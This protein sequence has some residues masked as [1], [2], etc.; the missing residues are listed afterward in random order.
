MLGLDYGLMGCA[1]RQRTSV[2]FSPT[3]VSGLIAWYDP[4]DLTTLFQDAA[5]TIP[6]TAD[7][8]PVGAMRD[9]SGNG[10]HLTQSTASARPT[11]R[12]D[13][14]AH[15]LV[16][17]GVSGRLEALLSLTNDPSLC[18]HSA[19]RILNNTAK[20]D[21]RLFDLGVGNGA[22]AATFGTGNYGWRHNNGN[23]LFVPATAGVDAVGSWERTTGDTYAQSRFYLNGVQ[24]TTSSS[25]NG[26]NTVTLAD[27]NFF[28]FGNPATTGYM[29]NVRLYGAIITASNPAA[30]RSALV[31]FLQQQY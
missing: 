26:T 27:T 29:A 14:A 22:L 23:N 31:S 3:D 16:S 15:W 30:D 8:Q 4:S 12:T 17:D 5:M 10:Y 13:G 11:Y 28:L 18:F 6:V 7:G 1:M 19:H 21:I 25:A 2:G 9:K 20:D 24:Q